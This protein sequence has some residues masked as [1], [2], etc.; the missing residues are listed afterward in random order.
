MEVAPSIRSATAADSAA[1]R[2]LV[3]AAL[4][5]FGMQL[6]SD[7]LD[8]D[9][10]DV[11]ASY[12]ENGGAFDVI[13]DAT[14]ALMGCVGIMPYDDV[15]GRRAC[16]LRKMY[17]RPGA[18]GHGLGRLLLGRAIDHAQR[19]GFETVVLE[20]ASILEDAIALYERNGFVPFDA[21]HRAIRC[22]MA[23]RRDLAR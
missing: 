17:L 13:V 14:G 5:E 2:A 11:H 4:Q 9:L 7:G 10:D 19:L 20:T 8:A 18:R 23:M 22:N 6:E 1:I 3:G 21:P 15:D 12:I 16:E